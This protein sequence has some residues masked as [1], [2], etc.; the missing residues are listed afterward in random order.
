MRKLYIFLLIICGLAQG[1][2]SQTLIRMSLTQPPP[3]SAISGTDTLVCTGHAV[4]LGGVPTA[5]GGSGEYTYMWSPPD[6]LDDPTSA[7]PVATLTE[8]RSYMLSVTDGQ[9]C[10]AVGFVSV[11]INPCLGI[12][13]NG[14]DQAIK[15]FPNPSDGIFTIQGLPQFTGD[16]V[17]I[18]VLNQLGQ[19]VFSKTS[20]PEDLRA[21]LVLDTG[22]RQPGIYFL[23]IRL[24]DR[25]FSHKLIVR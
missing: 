11:F 24:S 4:I 17:H 7:N 19:E 1:V 22:L 8:S 16:L 18:Q 20:L 12:D 15:V 5:T 10:Q 21:D 14:L 2:R 25:L 13:Q 23:R 9:G 3:L 6:G